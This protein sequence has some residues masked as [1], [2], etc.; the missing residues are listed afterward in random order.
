MPVSELVRRSETAAR[1]LY[2][3]GITFTVYSDQDMIDRILPFDV[4]PGSSPRTI[5]RS[6]RPASSNGSPR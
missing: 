6:L 2:N 5:G 3:L 4:I 1:E